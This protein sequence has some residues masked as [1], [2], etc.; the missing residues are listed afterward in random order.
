MFVVCM[1]LLWGMY[2]IFVVSINGVSKLNFI[3]MFLKVLGFVFFIVVG[4]FVF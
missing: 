3:I 2:M 1:I 4:L